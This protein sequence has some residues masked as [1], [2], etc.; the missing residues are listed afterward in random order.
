MDSLTTHL[1]SDLTKVPELKAG[2]FSH[3]TKVPEL[4]TG[5]FWHWGHQDCAGGGAAQVGLAQLSPKIKPPQ[6]NCGS[7]ISTDLGTPYR[8]LELDPFGAHCIQ[9]QRSPEHSQHPVL[10]HLPQGILLS[11]ISR[12]WTC[13]PFFFSLT[14]RW[15]CIALSGV[16]GLILLLVGCSLPVFQARVCGA[17]GR[18][19][20]SNNF[21]S[22]HQPYHDRGSL[23]FG[24]L[25]TCRLLWEQLLQKG[26][27]SALTRYVAH[28]SRD[29]SR[30]THPRL[31]WKR[32]YTCLGHES[33]LQRRL[34]PSYHDTWQT[35]WMRVKL[36]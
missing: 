34:T 6:S 7:I 30:A 9:G 32:I 18:E 25:L 17:G 20:G 24:T 16:A 14:A 31:G 27:A 4:T 10:E 1:F 12:F 3:L 5:V 29:Q 13:T 2:V 21:N 11:R 36:L 26:L 8:G 22:H 35:V 15:S 19:H 28:S 33:F 23:D